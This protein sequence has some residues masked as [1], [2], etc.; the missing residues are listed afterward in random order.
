MPAPS[1]VSHANPSIL[2]LRLNHPLHS[3]AVGP[4]QSPRQTCSTFGGDGDNYGLM[5]ARSTALAYN[6]L[7]TGL[8]AVATRDAS[9]GVSLWDLRCDL[10]AI[11]QEISARSDTSAD[12]PFDVLQRMLCVMKETLQ[13][14]RVLRGLKREAKVR[15]S[16]HPRE[17]NTLAL[18]L[19]CP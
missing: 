16:P 11:L 18:C 19:T 4:R 12:V 2:N 3:K 8:S 5:T 10:K 15:T 1:D 7:Q 9:A 17:L 6:A 14:R 13:Q